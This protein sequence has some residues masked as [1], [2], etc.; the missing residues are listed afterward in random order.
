MRIRPSGR[1][2]AAMATSGKRIGGV[3]RERRPAG[4]AVGKNCQA[5]KDVRLYGLNTTVDPI[6]VRYVPL[7]T[8]IMFQLYDPSFKNLKFHCIVLPR[9]KGLETAATVT[10]PVG[11]TNI[12]DP[13]PRLTRLKTV[14]ELL[15]GRICHL[16]AEP[17]LGPNDAP[18]Y[19]MHL[20]AAVLIST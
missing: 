18:L 20:V 14:A 19:L 16:V 12:E 11:E 7:E 8:D 2:V 9:D 10:A 4:G 5:W 6:A 1:L 3:Q 13:P 17:A 15:K